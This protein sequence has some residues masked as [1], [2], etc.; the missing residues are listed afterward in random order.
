MVPLTP[1]RFRELDISKSSHLFSLFDALSSETRFNRLGG[2]RVPSAELIKALNIKP[3]MQ[4]LDLGAGQCRYK[5]FFQHCHY[6]AIDFGKGK[7]GADYSKLDFIADIVKIPFIRDNSVDFC[8]NT[9]VLEHINEPS[10][11]LSEVERILKPGGRLFLYAPLISDE[12][13][14]PYD[15]F[16]YTSYGIK[17]LCQESRLKVVSLEPSNGPLET[18]INLVPPALSQVKSRNIFILAIL[19]FLKALFKF[20]LVP[21]FQRLDIYST[22]RT[23]PFCWLLV[24]EKEGQKERLGKSSSN[25]DEVIRSIICCAECKSNLDY[26]GSFYYCLRCGKKYFIINKQVVFN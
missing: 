14:V 16:R 10:I 23:F 18:V 12:H 3:G 15:F 13:Q 2:F 9:V 17:Y 6:L 19:Y 21:L 24:A 4:I 22:R 7:E 26:K 11:F 1:V 25:R 20:L 8:L 5:M